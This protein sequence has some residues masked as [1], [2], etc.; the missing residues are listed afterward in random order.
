MDDLVLRG[1]AKWPNV[2]AVYGWLGLDRRGDWRLQ[3]EA[4]TNPTVVAFINRNY[5]SDA[6]GRWFFQNGPQRVYVSLEYTP[7]VYR[8]TS[9]STGTL[10]FETHTGKPA[11]V[12]TAFIDETGALLVESEHGIGIV[13]DRDL[14]SILAAFVDANGN[15]LPEETLEEA[16][17]LLQS[18]R[19]A[20]V[21]LKLADASV[22]LKPLSSREVPARF[23]FE[24][25]PGDAQMDAAAR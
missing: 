22:K 25:A 14:Q 21:W 19:D 4:I 3:G 16:M 12:T 1:M 10:A 8:V 13:Q 23:R 17:A 11:T 24:P 7:L 5:E 9:G 6:E 20:P 18:G 15:A 2:P